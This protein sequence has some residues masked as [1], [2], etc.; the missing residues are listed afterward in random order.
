MY[1]MRTL[2]SE[3]LG[4]S[5]QVTPLAFV[6]EARTAFPHLEDLQVKEIIINISPVLQS[7]FML[8]KRK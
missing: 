2:D 1:K 7:T 3:K 4:N 5:P 8:L 6:L